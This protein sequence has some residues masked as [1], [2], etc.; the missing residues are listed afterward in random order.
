MIRIGHGYDVHRFD[1]TLG[2]CEIKLGGVSVPSHHPL[3]AH[4]DG[5]VALHAVCDALLGALAL[6]DIG[7]HFPD[8]SEQW[9]NADSRDLL[10]RVFT[11]V[12]DKG[13]ELGNLDVTII[14]Q[15]PK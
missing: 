7:E 6:G 5:D 13:Y 9:E 8:T 10:R 4:S 1:E 11:S 15:T 3:E 14:A 12:K 2:P